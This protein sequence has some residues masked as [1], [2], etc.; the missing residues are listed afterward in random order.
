MPF[1]FKG[2][3]IDGAHNAL[4]TLHDCLFLF[5]CILYFHVHYQLG[6]FF[7]LFGRHV[8]P[9]QL[10]LPLKYSRLYIFPVNKP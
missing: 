1:N 9:K 4:I 8:Y 3:C 10:T 5:L 6:D 7:Y 2:S